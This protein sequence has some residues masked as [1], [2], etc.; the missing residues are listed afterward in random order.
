M[1][2]IPAPNAA[3]AR[4]HIR[5]GDTLTGSIG[6]WFTKQDFSVNDLE[7][8]LDDLH[9]NFVTDYMADADPSANAYLLEA[10][11]MTAED[12]YHVTKAIDVD[13]G[14]VITNEPLSPANSLCVSFKNSKRGPW[15]R[16]R[17][18]CFGFSEQQADE[19]DFQSDLGNAIKATFQSLIDEPPSGWAW[20]I[21][22]KIFQ[23]EP[24]AQAVCVPVTEV[25]IRSLRFAFQK[26]RARRP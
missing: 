21:C 6:L 24:R 14:G 1:T 3:Y 4:L 15:N 26:R 10:Y 9:A 7:D 17:A 8:L 18:Y 12:G 19:K 20:V 22:S 2:F 25:L 13:G 5:V 16:G 23:G 11:D